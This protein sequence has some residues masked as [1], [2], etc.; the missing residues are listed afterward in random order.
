MNTFTRVMVIVVLVLSLIYVG[1]SAVL[2]A[3]REKWR[4]QY[5]ELE[6]QKARM[7]TELNSKI[8]ALEQ[9]NKKVSSDLD[10]KSKDLLTLEERWTTL[11]AENK[12]L[13]SQNQEWGNRIV[14]LRDSVDKLKE[15]SLSDKKLMRDFQ[16]Q[17]TETEAN[18]RAMTRERDDLSEL[19]QRL[20][21]DLSRTNTQLEETKKAL[22][23]ASEQKNKLEEIIAVLAERGIAVDEIAGALE[24]PP[25]R[26][27]V[28]NFDGEYGL[29]LINVGSQ[30]GVKRGF[31]FVVSRGDEYVSKIVI[32]E[33][34][35]KIAAGKSLE[36]YTRKP[37]KT[38][39]RVDTR[40]Y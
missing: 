32:H 21:G 17:L 33:V 34:Y 25:I 38:G 36:G 31:E 10:R 14:Q 28:V 18:L 8:K 11:D 15:E 4:S 3:T 27:S 9:E 24:V 37:I 5:L 26:G 22:A 16:A 29:V 20:E 2:F 35:D 7:E 40:L 12:S 39:D 13:I 23:K 1:V 6:E 19:R 30:D